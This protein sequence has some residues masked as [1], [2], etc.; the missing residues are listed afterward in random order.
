M[1]YSPGLFLIMPLK[2]VHKYKIKF[3]KI[4]ADLDDNKYG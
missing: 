1:L 3:I 2:S 4:L